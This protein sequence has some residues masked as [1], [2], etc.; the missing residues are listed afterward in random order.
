VTSSGMYVVYISITA[1][2]DLKKAGADNF[3][4]T[5]ERVLYIKSS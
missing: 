3:T 5:C 2:S 4:L 1:E